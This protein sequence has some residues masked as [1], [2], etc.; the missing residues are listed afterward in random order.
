MSRVQRG[1]SATVL[2]GTGLEVSRKA[3]VTCR[4][5]DQDVNPRAPLCVEGRGNVASIL[6]DV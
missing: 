1:F 3:R 5:D 4:G 6:E 2:R